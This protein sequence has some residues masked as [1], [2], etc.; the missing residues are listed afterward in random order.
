MKKMISLNVPEDMLK[1]FSLINQKKGISNTGAIN[2]YIA[3]YVNINIGLLYPEKSLEEKK[4][5]KLYEML[6][7]MEKGGDNEKIAALKWAIFELENQ[8]CKEE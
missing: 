5:D 1:K 6:N 3:E 2:T 4:I 8:Y 7:D